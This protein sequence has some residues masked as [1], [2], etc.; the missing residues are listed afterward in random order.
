M[1]VCFCL[2]PP[3]RPR[4]SLLLAAQFATDFCLPPLIIATSDITT[5]PTH[6]Q[7]GLNPLSQLTDSVWSIKSRA[8]THTHQLLLKC[9]IVCSIVLGCCCFF[10][11]RFD[12]PLVFC[13]IWIGES[14]ELADA[15]LRSVIARFSS[16]SFFCFLVFYFHYYFSFILLLFL[17]QEQRRH[18]RQHL[19]C[20]N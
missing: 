9:S 4:L 8:H 13:L 19:S 16:L 1:S 7:E 5:N 11:G 10:G 2:V 18:L 6:K 15:A 12:S 14:G 17:V 20:A 3:K